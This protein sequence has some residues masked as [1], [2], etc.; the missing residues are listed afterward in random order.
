MAPELE[1]TEQ[2]VG[3]EESYENVPVPE[4]PPPVAIADSPTVTELFESET[5]TAVSCAANAPKNPAA[6]A[7]SG[8]KTTAK[9][10]KHPARRI[11]A[12]TLLDIRFS[13]SKSRYRH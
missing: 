7:I 6:W 2:I 3:V 11:R 10:K 4:P 5:V 8:K 1:T 9:T 12:I 13:S